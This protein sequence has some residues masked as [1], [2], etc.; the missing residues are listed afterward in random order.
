MLLLLVYTVQACTCSSCRG[1]LSLHVFPCSLLLFFCMPQRLV[2]QGVQAT[3]LEL[4]A[5][6]AEGRYNTSV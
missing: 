6:T 4:D 3:Q 1:W 2:Q 5:A